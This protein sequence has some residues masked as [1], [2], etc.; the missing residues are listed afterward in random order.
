MKSSLVTLSCAAAALFTS[1]G[2]AAATTPAYVASSFGS[3]SIYYLDEDLNPLSSFAVSDAF[4]NGVSSDGTLIFA[5]YFMNSSVVA[6]DR[7]GQEQFRWSDPGLYRVQGIA[8]VDHYIAAASDD[9]LYLFDARQG[10]YTAQLSLGQDSVEGLAYDGHFLWSIGSTLVARD[11]VTGAAV[12]SIPNAASACPMGG[13]GIA[14][15]A[16]GTLVLSCS[17]GRWF[18]VLQADGSVLA[19][20]QN[21]IDMFDLARIAPVPEPGTAGLA[22]AGLAALGVVARRRRVR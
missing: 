17:D 21:D 12:K 3:N 16:P 8:F 6:Y 22:L 1:L 13:T 15:G 14:A 7:T 5:A 11:F 19:S 18:K 2:C 9:T 4:P 10:T 20:G